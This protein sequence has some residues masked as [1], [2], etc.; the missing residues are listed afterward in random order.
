[1]K[2]E[3]LN[4]MLQTE[5]KSFGLN[6]TD[7][8]LQKLDGFEYLIHHKEEQGFTFFGKLKREKERLRWKFLQLVSI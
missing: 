2:T 1:M 6:P 7:W 4:L 5:L 8:S 3:M